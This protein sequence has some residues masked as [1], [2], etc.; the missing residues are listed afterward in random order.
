[1][2]IYW[3]IESIQSSDNFTF[4]KESDP[5]VLLHIIKILKLFYSPVMIWIGIVSNILICLALK[6]GKMTRMSVIPFLYALALVDIV[7]LATLMVV[8][9]QTQGV[10]LYNKGGGCQTLT[11]VSYVC[12]FLSVWYYA[13]I[14]YIHDKNVVPQISD[15][16]NRIGIHNGSRQ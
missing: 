10:D 7:F 15:T 9:L 16:V 4:N 2:Q 13:A 5:K 6:K 11:Y 14:R 12:T 8:W 3:S 1:M